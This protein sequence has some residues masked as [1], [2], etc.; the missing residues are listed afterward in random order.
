MADRRMMR[1]IGKKLRMFREV[2]GY[3]QKSIADFLGISQP[4][5][6]QIEKGNRNIKLEHL[7]KLCNLYCVT[8]HDF[9]EH[10]V[11][12]LRDRAWKLWGL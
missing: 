5:Y 2:N 7:E 8:L 12:W 6:A 9:H 1:K 11:K 3:T 4:M 10:G